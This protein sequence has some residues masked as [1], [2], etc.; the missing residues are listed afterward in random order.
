VRTVVVTRDKHR[1]IQMSLQRVDR[2]ATIIVTLYPRVK[3]NTGRAGCRQFHAP[4]PG[5]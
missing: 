1:L 2:I 3:R 4:D 5:G